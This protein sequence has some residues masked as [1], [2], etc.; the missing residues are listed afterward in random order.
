MSGGSY[1]GC[2]DGLSMLLYGDVVSTGIDS[3][4]LPPC[5]SVA[6][7]A[8]V[9]VWGN[10]EAGDSV[11]LMHVLLPFKSLLPDRNPVGRPVR[12]WNSSTG[13]ICN[14][15]VGAAFCRYVACDCSVGRLVEVPALLARIN[16]LSECCTKLYNVW[17][18]MV[19]KS[20]LYV[21]LSA[22]IDHSENR[23]WCARHCSMGQLQYDC[24]SFLTKVCFC[25]SPQIF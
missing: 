24:C 8:I 22:C 9:V 17:L 20:L 12:V 19:C 3:G 7:T 10:H 23:M 16:I 1:S 6:T 5:N 2:L 4:S 11:D 15:K 25:L 21:V 14:D 18:V 13:G